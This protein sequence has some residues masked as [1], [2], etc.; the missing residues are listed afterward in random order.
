M[1]DSG[2][3]TGRRDEGS[4]RRSSEG[5]NL[6]TN[7]KRPLRHRRASR[8]LVA[9]VVYANLSVVPAKAGTSHLRPPV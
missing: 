7:D 9:Y 2:A 8:T 4:A 3:H 1:R 5:G 6:A